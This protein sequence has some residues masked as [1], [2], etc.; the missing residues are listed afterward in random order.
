MLTERAKFSC[1][2]VCPSS[3]TTNVSGVKV[4]LN[5]VSPQCSSGCDS[6]QKLLFFSVVIGTRSS[7]AMNHGT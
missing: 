7:N 4:E 1:C 5:A 3:D 2:R 6:T